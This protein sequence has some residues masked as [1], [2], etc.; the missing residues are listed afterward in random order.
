MEEARKLAGLI[1]S[2]RPF[3][4]LSGAGMST[5]SNLAD[6]RSREGLWARF[7]PMR[8]A[9]VSAMEREPEAFCAFYR[10]RLEALAGAEPNRGHRILAEWERE[11]KLEAIVTQNVDGL[12]QLAGSEKVLELHGTLRTARCTRCWAVAPGMELLGRI[13]CGRCGGRLRPDVVLFGENLPEGVLEEAE[14][15]ASLCGLFV[16]LGS[17]LAVSPAN[18]LPRIAKASGAS[19]AIVNREP[20]PLDGLADLVVRGEIGAVLAAADE[21]LREKGR[22]SEGPPLE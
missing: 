5:E 16:V 21:V 11:G 14:R 17:S 12:H 20:T 15:L 3:V 1:R 8:L 6:F 10:M 2:Y 22:A 9:T 4:V 13:E 18:A 7:D 19:L